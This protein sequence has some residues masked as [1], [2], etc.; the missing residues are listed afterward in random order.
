MMAAEFLMM[1]QGESPGAA[2]GGCAGSGRSLRVMVVDDNPSDRAA[3]R[4]EVVQAYPAAKVIEVG[5]P[6]DLDAA[7]QRGEYDLVVTDYQLAWGTGLGVL[8]QIKGRDYSTPVIMFTA[9]AGQE[10]AVAAMKEGL[11]DYVVKSPR[12][13]VRLRGTIHSVLEHA[14][15]RR[16]AADLEV[17]LQNLLERL[18]VGVFRVTMYGRLL[19]CNRAMLRLL[20]AASLDQAADSPRLRQ[21]LWERGEPGPL[22]LLRQAGDEIHRELT[23]EI[24]DKPR[25][26]AVRMLF[27][28]TDRQI[29]IDG[30]LEELKPSP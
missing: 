1:S 13:L 14:R 12:H 4:N 18:Q 29:V 27:S 2:A 25:Q 11:D 24:Q 17:R 16:K 7:M 5:Q 15:S 8:R 26:C 20:G 6:A 22:D 3:V 10:E 23:L 19:E 9:S 21:I 30:L 28:D